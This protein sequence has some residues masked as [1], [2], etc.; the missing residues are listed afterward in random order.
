[1]LFLGLPKTG[2]FFAWE[3]IG[4]FAVHNFGLAKE[5]VDQACAD[6]ILVD[7]QMVRDMLPPIKRTR[8]KYEAGYVVGLGGSPGM[9]GAPILA[10]FAALRSGA[11]I[12]RLLHPA[13][14]ESELAAAPPEIIRQGYHSAAEILQIMERASS[15]FIG[16]G[17]GTSPKT[18]ALLQEVL[19]KLNKPCV[20]DAE[21]LTL[22]AA[23]QIPLP[24]QAI[25]T[26]HYGEMKRLLHREDNPPVGEFHAACKA[27]VEKMQITLVLK[28]APTFIFPLTGKPYISACGDPGMATAGSGD[29]LTG[30]VAAFLA[31]THDPL[32]AALLANYFHGRA[33]ELAALDI[34]SPAMVASDIT[35]ALPLVFE[36][37]L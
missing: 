27:Y 1:T 26:P 15:C 17:I 23:H 36:E 4:R 32:Q 31:S 9:P 11:G 20:I 22:I 21:A 13:G 12:V 28:G 25:I 35:H 19:P 6:F 5:L 2:C 3:Q 18:L 8:H 30:I 37:L 24:P 33:G 34:T 29:V 7:E 16:P 14:M 10:S